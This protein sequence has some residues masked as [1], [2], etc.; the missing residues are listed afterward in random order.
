MGDIPL[1]I[2]QVARE[3]GRSAKTLKRLEAAGV[4]PQPQRG[5]DFVNGVPGW[6]YYFPDD[7]RRIK[8]ILYPRR[9]LAS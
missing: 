2:G 5:Q 9:D 3:V 6:R 4:L 7:V 1:T 8:A